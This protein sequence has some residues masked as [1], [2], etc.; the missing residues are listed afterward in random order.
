MEP[1]DPR[2]PRRPGP[3]RPR[4]AVRAAGLATL[5]ALAALAAALLAPAAPLAARAASYLDEAVAA[6]SDDATW[7]SPEIDGA[8]RLGRAVAAAN[9]SGAIAVAVFPDE[10]SLEATPADLAAGIVRRTGFPTVVVAVG[11][12]LTARS[13]VLPEGEAARIANEEES[14]GA[15]LAAA[16]TGTVERLAE[17]ARGQGQ[18]PAEG[19]AGQPRAAADRGSGGGFAPIV[20]VLVLLACLGLVVVAL[21]RRRRAKGLSA[22]APALVGKISEETPGDVRAELDKLKRLHGRY[23]D[24]SD[25]P[26]HRA[27]SLEMANA[28]A[29]ILNDT[30]ELFR[31]IAKKGTGEQKGI[32][33]VEYRD[34]LGKVA[35]LLG[36]DYY[37]DIITH[38]DLW[39]DPDARGAAV[40]DSIAAFADQ[41]RD[42]IK[43]T[44]ASQ[45]LRF[46]VSLDALARQKQDLAS[47][48]Y[49]PPN[50]E[51]PAQ[52]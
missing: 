40:R 25:S 7:V 33:R 12:D 44:N 19:A 14:A 39:D 36:D 35:D 34:Q 21:R 46:Q 31:R 43:Q 22:G 50:H 28:L 32:A 3:A 13:S 2:D 23:A 42:N 41:V 29:R 47:D 20:L 26:A 37:Y 49:R 1:R 10:A 24:P 6:L 9:T 4:G 52:P 16:L 51:R 18:G 30:S 48:L 5:A 45:D 11:G 38:P 8:A 15:N 17:A 27:E